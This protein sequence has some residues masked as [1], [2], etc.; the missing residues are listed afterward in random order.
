MVVR[1]R[2]LEW[3]GKV[4]IRDETEHTR[5]LAGKK[6]EGKCPRGIPRLR[7]KYTTDET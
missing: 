6:S 3:F 2:R 1:R 7:W 4:K 5:A